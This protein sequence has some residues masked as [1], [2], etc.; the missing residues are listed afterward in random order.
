[1]DLDITAENGVVV[2]SGI[3]A[4]NWGAQEFLDFNLVTEILGSN[5]EIG[6]GILAL[7]GVVSVTEKLDVTDLLDG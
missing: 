3:G 1:M 5:P 2:A 7:A 6:Y 4:A